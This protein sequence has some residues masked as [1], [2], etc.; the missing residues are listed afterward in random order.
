[1][2]RIEDLVEG[3]TVEFTDDYYFKGLK[4]HKAYKGQ[5]GTITGIDTIKE[6]P[7]LYDRGLEF[8]WLVLLDNG[9]YVYLVD[10]PPLRIIK[11]PDS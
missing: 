11:E 3:Q 1:M 6:E 4:T 8:G 10:K 7:N 9:K 5:R 2:V